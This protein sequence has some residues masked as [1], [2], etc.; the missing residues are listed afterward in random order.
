MSTGIRV[1][2]SF[3]IGWFLAQGTKLVIFMIRVKGRVT[4][5][6]VVEMMMKSGGMPSGH[7]ASMSAAVGTIGFFEGFGSVL[8]ALGACMLI[9]VVYDAINVRYAVGEQGKALNKLGEK[10]TEWKHLKVVEGHTILQV[11]VG[12]V[13]G[14]AVAAVMN[15]VR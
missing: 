10:E 5:K 3:V 4:F 11:I 9:I 7:S 12:I 13:I 1:I 2:L 15:C 6:D 8:F 14:I